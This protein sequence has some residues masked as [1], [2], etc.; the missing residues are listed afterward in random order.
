LPV[1][2]VDRFETVIN[3]KTSSKVGV[4]TRPSALRSPTR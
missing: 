2:A 4:T 1:E 3:L